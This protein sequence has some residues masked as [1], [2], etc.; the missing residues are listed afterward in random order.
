[1][2]AVKVR[3][4]EMLL[5]VTFLAAPSAPP[6]TNGTVNAVTGGTHRVEPDAMVTSDTCDIISGVA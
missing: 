3:V 4:D 6:H 5:S 1:M 2:L